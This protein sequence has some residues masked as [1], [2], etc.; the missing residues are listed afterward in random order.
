MILKKEIK[1]INKMGP[2]YYN[3][4]RQFI[5]NALYEQRDPWKKFRKDYISKDSA[6][7]IDNIIKQYFYVFELSRVDTSDIDLEFTLTAD[8]LINGSLK[9]ERDALLGSI[10]KGTLKVMLRG[11]LKFWKVILKAI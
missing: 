10:S 4:N 3:E 11:Y 1:I 5:I 6:L 2:F 9:T 8:D 7:I